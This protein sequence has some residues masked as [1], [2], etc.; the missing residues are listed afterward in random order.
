MDESRVLI[1]P[2][3]GSGDGVGRLLSLPHPKSGK[4]TCYLLNNGML[5]ELH[6]FKQPYTSWFLGDYVSQDGS[7]YS[8]TPV[9]PVF[10][11][12]PIFEEARMKKGDDL[13]KFRQLDEILFIQNYSGYHHLIPIAHDSMQLVCEIKE[14]GSSKFFRLDDSKAFAWLLCKVSQLKQAL[15]SLDKN[16]A[17]Q[18]ENNTLADA[19]AILGEYLKDEPWLKLLCNHLQLNLPEATKKVSNAETSLT[20]NNPASGNFMPEK[21]KSD[22]KTKRTS[23]RG[24][25]AKV[26]TE[27]QNIREMFTRASRRR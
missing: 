6:C 15:P 12:L 10:V 3:S 14:I 13:G 16:Y 21:D 17:A 27:S 26:E 4:K 20:E 2:T 8:A 22:S 24:K 18:D 5:Q 9:D 23:Q 1:G 11:L 7:L 19:V 25:K